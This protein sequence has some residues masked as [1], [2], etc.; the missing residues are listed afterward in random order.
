MTI[1]HNPRTRPQGQLAAKIELACGAAARLLSEAK[2]VG[3]WTLAYQDATAH[4]PH[5]QFRVTAQSA[6]LLPTIAAA[7]HEDPIQAA[8]AAIQALST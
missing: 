1:H 4:P 7:S 6:S 5:G 8:H 2:S 3:S